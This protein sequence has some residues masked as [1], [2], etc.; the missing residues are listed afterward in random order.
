M[1]R[2]LCRQCLLLM[3]SWG[4]TPADSLTRRNPTEHSDRSMDKGARQKDTWLT[5]ISERQPA[6]AVLMKSVAA[7][8]RKSL[9]QL[10]DRFGQLVYSLVLR[11]VR[12]PEDAEE[13][14]VDLFVRLW[15]RARDYHETRGTVAAWIVV[16]ARRLAIDRTRSKGYKAYRRELSIDN[17]GDFA[18]SFSANG[19]HPG[20]RLIAKQDT[21]RLR[22]AIGNLEDGRRQVLFLAYYEGLSHGEI[23]RHLQLPLGTVKT[24]LRAAVRDLRTHMITDQNV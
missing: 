4:R 15:Q 10:Y 22:N 13:V 21:D 17:Q 7:G 3:L 9:A 18:A 14:T 6:D 11:I 2:N 5:S 1:R 8:D 23:A 12:R 16:L 19:D 20:E 24:R